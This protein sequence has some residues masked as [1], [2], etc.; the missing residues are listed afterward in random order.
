MTLNDLE[1]DEDRKDFLL[2]VLK[3]IK[4]H[5]VWLVDKKDSFFSK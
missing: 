2:Y 4:A 3:E 1:L 5:K